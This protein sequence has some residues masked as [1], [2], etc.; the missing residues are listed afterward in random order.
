ME[1]ESGSTHST[2]LPFQTRG[3]ILNVGSICSAFAIDGMNPY[4]MAKHGVLGLTKSDAKDYAQ[5]GIRVNC[6]GPGWIKTAM[7]RMVWENEG[8]VSYNISSFSA[9]ADSRFDSCK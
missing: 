8:L 2:G 6:L 4:V 7:N 5:H 3:C 1:I 9:S